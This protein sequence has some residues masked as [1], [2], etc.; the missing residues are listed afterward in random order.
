MIT[1]QSKHKY[2][3]PS[4]ILS[5]RKPHFHDKLNKDG[6]SQKGVYAGSEITVRIDILNNWITSCP[7]LV[8]LNATYEGMN[9]QRNYNCSFSDRG[10]QL[11]CARFIRD[12]K[13]KKILR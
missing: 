8:T 10:I 7:N 12:I 11:I 4:F 9:Y 1:Y 5:E 13:N 6:Y 2:W 3:G